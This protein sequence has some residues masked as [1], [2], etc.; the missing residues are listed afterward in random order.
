MKISKIKVKNFRLL[1]NLKLDLEDNLSIVIGKNNCGKTSLLAIL[2]KFIGNKSSNN[3]FTY[4]DFNVELKQELY[5][6]VEDASRGWG[7]Q[8][9]I[10]LLIFIEYGDTDNLSNISNLMLD[11]DP[12]NTKVVLSFEYLLDDDN[13]NKMKKKFG[14]YIDK[15]EALSADR[16][17][18]FEN[19]IRSHHKEYFR[20][21]RKAVKFDTIIQDVKLDEFID[22]DKKKVDI[23]KIINFKYI[24]AHRAITNIDNDDTLSELS[25]KYYEKTEVNDSQSKAIDKFQ[26]AI[27]ETDSKLSVV[28][29][30]LFRDV[31]EKV[32]KFGGMKEDETI[33]KIISSLQSRE[34]LKGNTTVVYDD[35][36]HYLPESYN[37][38]GYLNLISMIFEIETLL[39]EF[40]KDN[41]KEIQPSDVNLLFIEE[42]EAHA[43]PQM[44]YIFIK[45]IK[46]IL[47]EGSDGSNGNKS[48]KLQTIITTHS[49]HIVSECEFDDIKYFKKN[50]LNSVESKNLKLLEIEY[51]K[52][53]E[54]GKA[55]FKFL[56]QYLTL[57]RSEIFFADK[58]IFIEGDTE[59]ILVPAM[60]KKID[61]DNIDA[62][63]PLLS[64][65]ISIIEVGNYSQ[66]FDKFIA[67]IG[68][69][70]LIITDIDSCKLILDKD[71]SGVVKK[72]KDGSDK[73]VRQ[74]VPV[75]DSTRTSNGSLRHYYGKEIENYLLKSGTKEIDYFINLETKNKV[76]LKENDEW[77]SSADGYLM[78]VYQVPEANEDGVIYN[79]RSFEDAFF[80]INRKLII[81]NKDKFISLK[82]VDYFNKKESP[83]GKYMYDSYTLA[84]KCIQS[85]PS[86]A[87][88]VL[89]NSTSNDK[90]NYSNWQIP[91]Y[92]KDGLI[93][94]KGN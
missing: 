73:M 8:E 39:S 44:Q 17:G 77:K 57:N 63:L 36:K 23:S 26:N 46:D 71:D 32:K 6:C 85:K 75:K 62:S 2:N 43:H 76:L 5:S 72:N 53:K 92:I 94:L 37:G 55:H 67:F 69:K 70:S 16:L 31:I 64:Q 40:R 19:F 12:D 91:K 74:A 33:I 50:N 48:F 34:L 22:L 42:P 60:M 4:D 54:I 13:F 9:G 93:W 89:L 81:D 21:Y 35:N 52:E 25:S 24:G 47:R 88:D 84:E 27:I 3:N 56:K 11:L 28:Y 66:I 20:I 58:V 18:C 14:E 7:K 51:S 49:S 59:R 29:N 83:S 82:E 78:I 1:K 61:E 15:H 45:N 38:L 87:M 80:H 65:N 10:S 30:D 90:S 68:I 41:H 86:F 79:A